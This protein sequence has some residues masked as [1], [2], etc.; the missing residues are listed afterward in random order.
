MSG[1]VWQ[2]TS[3]LTSSYPYDYAAE[4]TF[5]QPELNHLTAVFDQIILVPRVCKGKLFPLPP[6]V[7]VNEQYAEAEK[8]ARQ[9]LES[10]SK[11]PALL[12]HAGIILCHSGDLAIGRAAI[13]RA[14]GCPLAFGP[15]ERKLAVEARRT[16]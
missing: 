11:N 10:G 9:A 6:G 4:Y 12:L 1:N 15:L 16:L 14:L 13:E 3:S 7:E 2:W 5:I 8:L